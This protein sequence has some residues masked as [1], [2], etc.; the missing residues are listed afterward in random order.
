MRALLNT[1]STLRRSLRDAVAESGCAQVPEL[2][3]DIATP[4]Y[5]TAT[6]ELRTIN[7]WLGPAGTVRSRSHSMRVC[8][9]G[10]LAVHSISLSKRFFLPSWAHF[11]SEQ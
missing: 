4:D 10:R 6:G 9:Q 11:G 1:R 8:W 2:A 5:C 7:A 3:R